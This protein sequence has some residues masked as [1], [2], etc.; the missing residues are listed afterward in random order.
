MKKTLLLFPL[1][2]FAQID[3]IEYKGLLHISPITANSII[4]IHKNDNFNVEK[5]DES[6]K[7]LY[8]TGYFQTIK[9]VKEG[10]ETN[11]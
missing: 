4:K 6:I 3:K 9:A 11:G 1:I 2:L 5:I 10:K 7:A 8:K